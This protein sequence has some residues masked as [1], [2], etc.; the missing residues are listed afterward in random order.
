MSAKLALRQA[1]ATA[2]RPFSKVQPQEATM[3]V[4]MTLAAFMLLTA[5]YVLK[6]V[7]EPLILLQGGA[8]VKLYA[9]AGQ[10]VLMVGVVH[11]YGELARR[12]GRMKLLVIVFL[13]FVSNLVVFAVLANT[14]VPI[15][16]AFFLWV[17][18]FSYTVVAQ[19]WGLAADIYDDEQGKRLF[20]IIGAGSSIGAVVGGVVATSLVAFGPPVLMGTAVV[21][22]LACVALI[23]WVERHAVSLSLR[24]DEPP[25]DE[26]LAKESAWQLLAHDRYLWF[27]AGMVVFLNWVNSSGEYLL[28]RTLLV[29]AKQATAND[30]DAGTFI[31]AFKGNFY[32]WQ[33]SLG[34][35]LQLFAVSRILKLVGV[36]RALFFLPT[37]A[38]IAYG[39]AVFFP[40][41]AVMRIVK[42]GENSLQYSLA[43][44]SRHA[45]FLV[46]SRVEKF[47]GK[48]AIDT[49]AVR[50]GAIVSA[51][52]VYVGTRLDWST[53]TFAAINVGLVAGW[54]GF[55][56]LIGKEHRLRSAALE[57]NSGE[58]SS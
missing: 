14:D 24:H 11:L 20:P 12:V 46:A 3:V 2:L 50:V 19:F 49:V 40:V 36:R 35:G 16:L 6:T 42:I 23:V 48:T 39:G 47:V 30:V 15:G 7:R 31:G 45:L 56:L 57:T 34:V 28:D 32:V 58:H 9:R 27:I 4:L 44:T 10:A 54:I 52:M 25:P 38:L 17:G 1:V 18:V 41:L 21:I 26:P 13:F 51:V 29:A 53:G 37:F 22:L 43:D 55:V 8:E 5:Y 33:N